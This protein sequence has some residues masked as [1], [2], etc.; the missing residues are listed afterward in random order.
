MKSWRI[1]FVLSVIMVIAGG[2]IW[3]QNNSTAYSKRAEQLRNA[4][5]QKVQSAKGRY[6]T[7]RDQVNKAY[8][9][10]LRG[11][12]E[13]FTAGYDDD[14]SLKQKKELEPVV[15]AGSDEKK[16]TS[17]IVAQEAATDFLFLNVY[18]FFYY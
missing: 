16:V 14:D 2:S 17:K 7:Y 1:L 18:L 6:E 15:Y 4:Y 11:E 5:K 3:A 9:A 10:K 8:A 12:W 13:G